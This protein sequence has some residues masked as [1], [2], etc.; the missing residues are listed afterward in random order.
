MGLVVVSFGL[1][2]LFPLE[3]GAGALEIGAFWACPLE[4][5]ALG[6]WPKGFPA[7]V[8][9]LDC[10][11]LETPSISPSACS[12]LGGLASVVHC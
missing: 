1:L 7:P 8:G 9:F 4:E 10:S 12:F 2:F 5:G 6:A 11:S 3:I